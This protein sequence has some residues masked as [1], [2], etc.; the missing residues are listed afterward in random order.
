[1]RMGSHCETMT[2]AIH[3]IRALSIDAIERAESGHP[4]LPMGAIVNGMALHGGV[5]PFGGTFLVFS[6]YLRPAIRVSALMNLPAI[7]V[8]TH[9]SLAVGEDGPHISRSN[10]FPACV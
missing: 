4:G 1:M 7:F 9:D 8:F 5:I 3:A 6:D 2:A 10:S